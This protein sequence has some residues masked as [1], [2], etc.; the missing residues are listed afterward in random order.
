MAAAE[1]KVR[2]SRA[3]ADTER[4]IEETYDATLRDI[5]AVLLRNIETLGHPVKVNED[6]G[7]LDVIMGHY[8]V[9]AGP[10]TLAY[11]PCVWVKDPSWLQFILD[12]YARQRQ[13]LMDWLNDYVDEVEMRLFGSVSRIPKSGEIVRGHPNPL[14]PVDEDEL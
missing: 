11:R 13:G 8:V 10:G 9:G 7:P 5:A 14:T 2:Y 12:T 3:F 6:L 4:V 1:P